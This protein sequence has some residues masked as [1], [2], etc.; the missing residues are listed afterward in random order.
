MHPSIHRSVRVCVY[1]CVALPG[2][3]VKAVCKVNFDGK[4]SVKEQRFILL[5]GTGSRKENALQTTTTLSHRSHTENP[6][7]GLQMSIEAEALLF[8]LVSVF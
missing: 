6:I 2:L 3:T 8:L 1:V 5:F 4:P 7:I